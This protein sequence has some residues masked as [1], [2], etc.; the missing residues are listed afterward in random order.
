V[1][2]TDKRTEDMCSTAKH[3]CI[4]L[5]VLILLKVVRFISLFDLPVYNFKGRIGEEIIHSG[6]FVAS[7]IC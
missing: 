4:I 6:W 1:T 3:T 5:D 2:C 7:E